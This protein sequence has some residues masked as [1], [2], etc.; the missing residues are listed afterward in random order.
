VQ[1]HLRQEGGHVTFRHGDDVLRID[2]TRFEALGSD[3]FVW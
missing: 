2:W 3:D 1:G